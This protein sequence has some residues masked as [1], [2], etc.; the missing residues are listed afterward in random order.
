[1][2]ASEVTI[3]DEFFGMVKTKINKNI[4]DFMADYG[5]RQGKIILKH[6]DGFVAELHSARRNNDEEITGT[7]YVT[8]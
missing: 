5:F 1:M 3:T 4:N 6:D 7:M 8:F 2:I